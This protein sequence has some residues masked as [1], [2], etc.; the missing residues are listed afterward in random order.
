MW[1]KRLNFDNFWPKL[2]KCSYRLLFDVHVDR[3]NKN[4]QVHKIFWSCSVLLTLWDLSDHGYILDSKE[5]CTLISLTPLC[6]KSNTQLD[7]GLVIYDPKWILKIQLSPN[8]IGFWVNQQATMTYGLQGSDVFKL[9]SAG[10]AF[11]YLLLVLLGQ[12][13]HR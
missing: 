8:P 11:N 10:S 3:V 13:P 12:R 7:Q 6:S 1:Q 2:I 5:Y 9:K 4:F